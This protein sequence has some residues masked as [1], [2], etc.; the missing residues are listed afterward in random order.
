MGKV[1]VSR[2]AAPPH[3]TQVCQIYTLHKTLNRKFIY[4]LKKLIYKILQFKLIKKN[5]KTNTTP[6][7]NMFAFQQYIAL[8]TSSDQADIM[9]GTG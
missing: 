2:R 5:T 9:D 6:E 4:F 7:S 8:N 3:I 1:S